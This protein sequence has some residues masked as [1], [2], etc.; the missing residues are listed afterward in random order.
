MSNLLAVTNATICTRHFTKTRKVTK[1]FYFSPTPLT[2]PATKQSASEVHYA[3]LALAI[4]HDD[5]GGKTHLNNHLNKLPP[6]PAYNYFDEPTI[7]AQIDHGGSFKTVGPHP[8][9]H[10]SAHTGSTGS[11]GSSYPLISPVSQHH[12]HPLTLQLQQDATQPASSHNQ[13]HAP[14][15]PHTPTTASLLQLSQPLGQHPGGAAAVLAHSPLQQQHALPQSPSLSLPCV[16]GTG[17]KQY[18]REIVTVRTPLAFSQQ[19]SCV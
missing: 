17:S 3:E 18:L 19:E 14:H 4:P 6:P 12:H 16:N 10:P 11:T 1:R 7:Y 2:R 9:A 13:H 15:T 5:T 8:P